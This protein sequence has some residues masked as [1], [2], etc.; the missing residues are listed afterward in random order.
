MISQKC[1]ELC[2]GWVN[3]SGWHQRA[4]SELSAI[5]LSIIRPPSAG[6]HSRAL[7][8]RGSSA[9]CPRPLRVPRR[10][11]RAAG[12]RAP[13]KVHVPAVHRRA[14]VFASA[15]SAALR[16]ACGRALSPP[17]AGSRPAAS[18]VRAH[19]WPVSRPPST[20]RT[21]RSRAHGA[22]VFRLARTRQWLPPRAA[23]TPPRASNRGQGADAIP[24][25]VRPE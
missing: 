3:G 14:P 2:A 20:A 19:G 10:V 9:P 24:M 6:N 18:K 22:T 17:P 16:S 23:G 15:P 13:C 1:P 5:S 4:L 11:G 12:R 7:A 25:P 8:N 21:L